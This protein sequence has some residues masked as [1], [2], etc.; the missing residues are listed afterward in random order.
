MID[1]DLIREKPEVVEESAQKR[2]QVFQ[3][4]EASELDS[5]R[6]RTISEIDSLRARRNEVSRELGKKSEKPQELIKDM[7]EVGA[8]ISKLE[9]KE[10]DIAEQLQNILMDI[11]NIPGDTTPFGADEGEN[12]IVRTVGNKPEFD[13]DPKPHWDIGED[14][15]IIDFQRGVKVS[16][17]R[18]YLLRNKGA[19]LQRAIISWMLDLHISQ[20]GYS[21]LYLPYMVNRATVTGSSH[22]PHFEENMYHDEEDDLFMV[23]TAEAPVTGMFRDEIIDGSELPLKFVSHTPCWRREK[24]SAG[25][26][27]RGI[28]RVHQFD[29]V[30]MYKFVEP[31]TSYEE[32]ETL[33]KDAEEVCAQ[34][35]IPHRV[36]ELCTGDLGFAASKS[37]DVEMWGSG[38]SEWLEVSSCSNCTDFQ[39]RRS[40]IRYRPSEGGRPRFVHTLNG[41][42]LAV[43]R[44]MI[45]ILEHYQQ[46][47][48]SVIVPD[49][50]K[51]F[52]GF[53]SIS[54]D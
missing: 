40:A 42:G 9:K 46:E 29:K 15:G 21:E 16:Q 11:P 34:L 13:F 28:K 30:E 23:P 52:A 4:A 33:V 32:L 8:Q 37:Y 38:T 44:V 19:M 5:R 45:A 25:R 27:T 3:V 12:V 26:D 48:G 39:S 7:R 43:P 35:E 41:S 54:K 24:F 20:H 17:T 1:I 14:L 36:L 10:K 2:G 49:V 47:D 51:P 31:H 22:L 18:F 6:R 53:D 50:L